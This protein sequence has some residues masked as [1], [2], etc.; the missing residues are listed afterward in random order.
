MF[1]VWKQMDL[2][3]IHRATKFLEPYSYWSIEDFGPDELRAVQKAL[4]DSE[5]KANK[6]KKRYTRRGVND[7]INCIRTAWRGGFGRGLIRFHIKGLFI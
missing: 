6:T 3:K 7:P 5:Y 1:C 2:P 4:L